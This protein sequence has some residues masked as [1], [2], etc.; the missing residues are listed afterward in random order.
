[1]DQKKCYMCM[2][3]QPIENFHK[4][5]K[6]KNGLQNW[7]KE[8]RNKHRITRRKEINTRVR[9]RYNPEKEKQRSMNRRAKNPQRVWASKAIA[10]HKRR[11]KPCLFTINDLITIIPK[12]NTCV[13]CKKIF[14]WNCNDHDLAAPSL[15]QIDCAQALILDNAQIICK[16]CN[17]GKSTDTQ[18]GYILNC[19]DVW[20]KHRDTRRDQT[21]RA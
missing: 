1:M 9:E 5:I 6:R 21:G 11:K 12:N 16:Q 17:G 13:L 3:L 10:G 7:C 15:D 20:E 19:R 8:C 14:K 4:N 2:S 18:L